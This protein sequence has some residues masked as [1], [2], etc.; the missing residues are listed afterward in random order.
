MRL[1]INIFW[2]LVVIMP[3]ANA[4]TLDDY[5]IEAADNNPGLQAIYKEFEAALLRV[6]QVSSL[7]D[8][9]FSFGY[10]ISPVE[11]RVGP[12]RAKLSLSQMFP[13]FGTLKARDDAASLLA[14][15][16][17]QAFLEARNKLYYQL[18][19]AYYPLYELGKWKQAEE[20]NIGIL[21]AYKHIAN[22]KFENGDGAMVDV[23]RVEIMLEEAQ[24]RMHILNDKEKPLLSRFNHLMARDATTPVQVEDS[25]SIEMFF[26][27]PANDTLFSENPALAELELKTRAS[28]A[29]EEAAKKQGLPNLGVGIDYVIV[30]Q[31]PDITSPDN[32]K[33]VL[34]PMVSVSIPLFR[35][36]YKAAEKEAQLMQ[37]HFSLQKRNLLNTLAAE[38]DHVIFTLQQQQ[39]LVELYEQQIRLVRQSLNLLF[40]AYSNSGKD[41]EEVLMMQQRLLGYEKNKASALTEFQVAL[42]KANYLT[43]KTIPYDKK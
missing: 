9:T 21:N 14:E 39:Q 3:H 22:R 4:Q 34:M 15:A 25:L 7:P 13:W 23:L 27:D 5:F 17:Y 43:A 38:F 29:G 30:G 11:T 6:P 18:A 36:K 10:F 37:E 42:A 1:F 31:N 8:P 20:E 19:N 26:D 28:R 16:R 35:K 32:G 24:T 2:L 12:Q 41:F 40:T 33:D